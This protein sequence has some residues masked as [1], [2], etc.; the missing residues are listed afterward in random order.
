VVP[1]ALSPFS[2]TDDEKTTIE[3]GWEEEASTTVE[4][5]EVQEKMRALGLEAKTITGPSGSNSTNIS[6]GVDEPTVDDQRANAALSLITPPMLARLVI[7]AGNDAGQEIEIQPGKN[8][9]IGRGIDN[10][11]VLTD[12]AVS[13][14][15]FDVRQDNGTWI[16]NDRGSGNG[17]LV[18]G[19]IEDQ[20]FVLANG[21]TIE[22]G[23]TT[24]RFE[25]PNA[26]R[27]PAPSMLQPFGLDEEE[28][29]TVAGKPLQQHEDVPTPAQIVAPPVRPKTQPPPP[30]PM[31]P[32]PP[33]QPPPPFPPQ[34]LQHSPAPQMLSPQQL[35]MAATYA[36][37]NM[38]QSPATTL[39]M[40]P[41]NQIAQPAPMMTPRNQIAQPAPMTPRNQMPSQ[42]P[43]MM[44]GN[45]HPLPG[46][47]PSTLPGQGM[48]M[49]PSQPHGQP[50]PF[51]YPNIAEV[52]AYQQM[53][54]PRSDPTAHVQPM[55]YNGMSRPAQ[56]AQQVYTPPAL[57]RRTKLLLGGIGLTVL[58]AVATIGII[59]STAG[60]KAS[61]A[62]PGSATA[63]V[64][65][66]PGKGSA[67]VK[68]TAPAPPTP[69]AG[70][71]PPP[72]VA[73]VTPPA[74]TPPVTAPKPP[75]PTPAPAPP[76]PVPVQPKIVTVAPPPPPPT[77]PPPTPTVAAKDPPVKDPPLTKKE[78]KEKE[79]REKKDKRIA[80]N[81]TDDTTI[82]EDPPTPSAPSGGGASA[83]R[84][85][86]KELYANQRFKEAASTLRPYDA[87][88]AKAMDKVGSLYSA[89]TTPGVR[90]TDAYDKLNQAKSFDITAGKG[91]A[92]AI[93][94]ALRK[95]APRA[96]AS[97]LGTQNYEMAFQVLRVA[98][99]KLGVKNDTT[100]AVHQGLEARA[101][102]LVKQ[103]QQLAE[104]D[105]SQARGKIKLARAIVPEDSPALKKASQLNLN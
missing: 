24:F 15:H 59:K 20:P 43:P 80:Q 64:A 16:I 39:P 25:A 63:K 104:S 3:S 48:P 5:G 77:P 61:A 57:S 50:L 35:A 85:K 21:D 66:P 28:A 65:A 6:T 1:K 90:A 52:Q 71:A 51:T 8:Y 91:M 72:K 84:A 19:R 94:D 38:Q 32:R 73:V 27:P 56:A 7:T 69:K 76:A 30:P 13:R 70:S 98:E 42:Q 41:R 79:K 23:N 36:P 18:N 17:T 53:T 67:V 62:A 88:A 46:V 81:T 4:Q 22:I 95:I 74:P 9:T 68:A 49:Q 54:Q 97:Y 31:R 93:N 99:E 34:M 78:K 33:T 102:E 55:P 58:A 10:D 100:R 11:L 101:S 37:P 47:L 45:G 89:A 82:T 44:N 96:A 83:A 29:S 92:D 60:G 2:D 26:T 14:K 103:A 40:T 86:A 87:T 75:T 105:P 12:I